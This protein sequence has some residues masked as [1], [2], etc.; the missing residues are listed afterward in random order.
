MSRQ[1]GPVPALTTMGTVNAITCSILVLDQLT[2]TFNL[3]LRNV[4]Q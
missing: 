2:D 1:F 4:E 3:T